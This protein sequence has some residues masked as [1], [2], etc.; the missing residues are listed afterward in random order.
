MLGV[1]LWSDASDKKAVIWCED[2]GDLAFVNASETL[3]KKDDFFDAGDLVQFDMH[4]KDSTR[5]A[6]NTRLVFEQAGSALP[7]ALRKTSMGPTIPQD[8][9]AEVISFPTTRKKPE[10]TP[11]PA[12]L[13]NAS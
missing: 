11:V 13:S 9:Q 8:S 2:H 4:M 10:K 6:C 5:H 7:V 12:D 1:V 3:L